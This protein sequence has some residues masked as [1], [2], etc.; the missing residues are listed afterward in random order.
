L[1][2]VREALVEPVFNSLHSFFLVKQKAFLATFAPPL[3]RTASLVCSYKRDEAQKYLSWLSAGSSSVFVLSDYLLAFIKTIPL[4]MVLL[5][6]STLIDW[7]RG[8]EDSAVI[9]GMGF[10]IS[11]VVGVIGPFLMSIAMPLVSVVSRGHLGGFGWEGVLGYSLVE[12]YPSSQP[13]TL[14]GM[15]FHESERAKDPERQKRLEHSSYY[16]DKDIIERVLR[17]IDSRLRGVAP[18]PSRNSDKRYDQAPIEESVPKYFI[19]DL[20]YKLSLNDKRSGYLGGMQL[21]TFVAIWFHFLFLA[22]PGPG[23]ISVKLPYSD[24]VKRG[25]L[26]KFSAT[27][28]PSES[29]MFSFDPYSDPRVSWFSD[30]KESCYLVGYFRTDAVRP[31]LYL[32]IKAVKKITKSR[33]MSRAEMYE[34]VLLSPQ[35][36]GREYTFNQKIPAT[37]VMLHR[38]AGTLRFENI[39]REKRKTIDGVLHYICFRHHYNGRA[40]PSELP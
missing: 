1:D 35:K 18:S 30:A 36:N 40:T 2:E 38:P 26:T 15:D 10:G 16:V 3:L 8:D 7:W 29:K 28:G 22:L 37:L 9:L 11:L 19:G 39:E 23:S 4:L 31:Q 13:D 14:V 5:F 20:N 25:T 12:V 24:E 33:H 6:L 34:E 21:V 17:W 27:V 32:H